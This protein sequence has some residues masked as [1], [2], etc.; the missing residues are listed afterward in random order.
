MWQNFASLSWI[1]WEESSV[2]VPNRRAVECFHQEYDRRRN[3][4]SCGR[5][6]NH[7]RC[8]QVHLEELARSIIHSSSDAEEA[9]DEQG[10]VQTILIPEHDSSGELLQSKLSGGQGTSSGT[11]LELFVRTPC[12]LHVF[13]TEHNFESELHTRLINVVCLSALVMFLLILLYLVLPPTIRRV[14]RGS[15]LP[16]YL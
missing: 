16:S 1:E 13:S 5:G 12:T 2:A 3:C 11:V 4:G 15:K 7:Q 10:Q 8:R 9:T 6:G 14:N